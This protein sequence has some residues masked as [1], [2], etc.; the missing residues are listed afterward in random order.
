VALDADGVGRR[1]D[2]TVAG[3]GIVLDEGLRRMI[4]A[5]L[6]PALV[7]TAA[8]ATAARAV[9][10]DDLGRLAAGALA[11]LVWWDEAWRPRRVWVGGREVALHV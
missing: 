9:R 8:T 2:G 7:L 11:D 6:P 5:G 10:R 3:A 4:A 1:L